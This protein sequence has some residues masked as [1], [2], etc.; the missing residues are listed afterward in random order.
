M[1]LHCGG[2]LTLW[3]MGSGVHRLSSC[4]SG[5]VIVVRGLGCST[6]CR[7]LVLWPGIKPVAPAVDVQSL[8]CWATR[9]VTE[10]YFLPGLCIWLWNAKHSA[11]IG[12]GWAE[13]ISLFACI[14]NIPFVWRCWGKVYRMRCWCPA[15]VLCIMKYFSSLGWFL[16]RLFIP[17]GLAG[18]KLGSDSLWGLDSWCCRCPETCVNSGTPLLYILEITNTPLFSPPLSSPC[19]PLV[20]WGL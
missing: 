10:L 3:N 5:S 8:K 13:F 20:G 17:C 11:P 1:G 18:G 14:W 9:N 19:P 7:I 16:C 6:A 15:M 2:L 4:G 12:S